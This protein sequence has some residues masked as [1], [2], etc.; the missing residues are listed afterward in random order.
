MVFMIIIEFIGKCLYVAIWL[1]ALLW[2]PLLSLATLVT[3]LI[4]LFNR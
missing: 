3:F 1:M 4:H 2:I